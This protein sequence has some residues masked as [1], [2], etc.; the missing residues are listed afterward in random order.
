MQTSPF[1]YISKQKQLFFCFVLVTAIFLF[2]PAAHSVMPPEVYTKQA[3][4]SAQ[5]KGAVSIPTPVLRG[6]ESS[7]EDQSLHLEILDELGKE[8]ELKR[9][10]HG[11]GDLGTAVPPKQS[12]ED[13]RGQF[14]MA[15]GN[16]D[17]QEVARFI[18]LGANVNKV[19]GQ[20][21]QTPLMM[22][23]SKSM[24]ELLIKH[25]ANVKA[26]DLDGGSMIHYAVTKE[27]AA[28]LIK[29]FTSLGLDPNLKGW[30]N[31]PAIFVACKYFHESKAF[32]SQI[33]L[34]GQTPEKAISV[35]QTTLRA[36]IDA[37]A[38]INAHDDAGDTV[39]TNAK[40]W[41]NKELV[42]LLI[43]LGADKNTVR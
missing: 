26:K 20:T 14:I 34:L 2:I 32:D 19:N 9:Q 5:E 23:E 17:L 25:G 41:G 15:I 10:S 40:T 29:Y 43:E 6:K 37:G 33:T 3:K 7:P 22:A 11:H 30:D 39:L 27:N 1:K 4:A 28:E 36:L 16:N 24:T 8:K 12:A 38:D 31:E 42:T 18:K 21:G 13:I 35:P